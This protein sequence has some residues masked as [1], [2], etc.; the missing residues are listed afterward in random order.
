MKFKW[1][2]LGI[3]IVT[4]ES[5]LLQRCMLLDMRVWC[6]CFNNLLVRTY[7]L[8]SLDIDRGHFLFD[9]L[10]NLNNFWC[11][12]LKIL[13]NLKVLNGYNIFEGHKILNRLGLLNGFDLLDR[14]D[15]FNKLKILNALNIPKGD[16]VPDDFDI[17]NN[18][19]SL[20]ILILDTYCIRIVLNYV[21]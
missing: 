16:K 4:K 15:L 5:T 17:L 19:S 11:T 20:D 18:F 1:E 8:D 3:K 7:A 13:N 6:S 14:S 2:A 12:C 10:D 21:S 9:V